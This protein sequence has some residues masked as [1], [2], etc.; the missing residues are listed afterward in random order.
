MKPLKSHSCQTNLLWV[1]GG[2][3][4]K[5]EQGIRDLKPWARSTR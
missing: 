2:D 3:M 5:V 1:V 4:N